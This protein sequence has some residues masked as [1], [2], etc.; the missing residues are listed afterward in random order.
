MRGT[1]FSKKYKGPSLSRLPF[2]LKGFVLTERSTAGTQ[3]GRYTFR[4]AKD[5]N[6]LDVRAAV[7]SFFKVDVVGVNTLSVPAKRR[8]FR[9]VKGRISGYKKAIVRIKEGQ[10]IDLGGAQ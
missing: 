9:G 2:I 7:E 1:V 3:G 6:K 4:I 8:R 5:A 10:V